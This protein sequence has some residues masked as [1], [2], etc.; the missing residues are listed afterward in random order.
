MSLLLSCLDYGRGTIGVTTRTLKLDE[1][2][3]SAVS[4]SPVPAQLFTSVTLVKIWKN[5]LATLAAFMAF[6]KYFS[7]DTQRDVDLMLD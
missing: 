1:H 6:G 4:M 7:V 5:I 2:W 3:L